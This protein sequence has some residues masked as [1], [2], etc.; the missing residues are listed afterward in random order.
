MQTPYEFLICEHCHEV[1]DSP[2][3]LPCGD[4]LCQKHLSG[5]ERITCLVC[6]MDHEVDET[7]FPVDKLLQKLA[8]LNIKC[9]QSHVKAKSTFER[10][11]VLL[12]ELENLI[13]DPFNYLYEY[14]AAIRNTVCI[15]KEL[16]HLTDS[17]FDKLMD[18]LDSFEKNR[19]TIFNCDQFFLNKLEQSRSLSK[20]IEPHL[21]EYNEDEKYWRHFN[22][23]LSN[24]SLKLECYIKELKATVLDHKQLT[25]AKPISSEA[26]IEIK[27]NQV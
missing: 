18:V 12:Y 23:E 9:G 17:Q 2:V 14:M 7:R 24:D 20:K 21:R 6:S 11:Q 25:L 26:Y 4:R 3:I 8:I 16:N 15:E 10:H 22:S 1:F 19:K 27:R 13:E 5:Q